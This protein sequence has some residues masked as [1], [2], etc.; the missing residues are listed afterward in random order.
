MRKD[1]HRQKTGFTLVEL[2]V[3]IGIITIL[4]ALLLPAIGAARAFSRAAEC[5]SRLDQIGT[6]IVAAT[7]ADEVVHAQRVLLDL[8]RH[9]D[10][11]YEVYQC[12]EAAGENITNVHFGFN[13][14]LYRFHSA[15]A[16]KIVAIDYAVSVVDPFSDDVETRWE[17]QVRPRHF[18]ACNVLFYDGHV[19]RLEPDV[20]SPVVCD[21][22]KEYWVPTLDEQRYLKPADCEWIG[23]PI[24]DPPGDQEFTGVTHSSESEFEANVDFGTSSSP[25]ADGYTRATI[26]DWTSLNGGGDVDRSTGSDL[27]RDLVFMK[28]GTY[29]LTGVP[30]GTYS[31]TLYVGDLDPSKPLRDDNDVYLQGLL[32]DNDLDTPS[33]TMVTRSYSGIVVD[34]SGNLTLRVV[35]LGGS[36]D[37]VLLA[38]MDVVGGGGGGSDG[39]PPPPPTMEVTIS[40]SSIAENGGTAT[41]TVTRSDSSGALAVALSSDNEAKASVPASVTI[42]DGQESV[43]FTITAIDDGNYA[44][45][46]TVNFTASADDYDDANASLVVTNDDPAFAAHVDFGTSTS[47]LAVGYTRVTIS[48]WTNL[49]SSGSADRSTG[50][51]LKRDLVFM[52]D[53]TYALSGVPAG[54]Y[55][56]TLYIGDLDPTKPL[57]DDNDV[58]L[59][60]ILVDNDLDT[61]SGTML[62]RTYSGIVVAGGGTLTLRIVGLGGTNDYVLVA[63]MDVEQ[64]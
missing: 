33:A 39:G 2:L 4:I 53:G 51:D 45:D 59:Q 5:A 3:V 30:E 9:M 50:G 38:G 8:E 43:T 17:A 40:P 24:P 13:G 48:G 60:G 7:S 26:G 37:Y 44:P 49:T 56:V 62:A 61:P 10:K 29:T 54:T 21:N 16:N 64:Q 15:D 12:P 31:V 42:P 1:T 63:G 25:L 46:V 18:E 32:V 20:I 41:G 55:N 52:H 22:V 11:V 6:A 27:E 34:S 57:R 47:P 58:Y 35:G 14:R 19:E 23:P 28:D 36:N